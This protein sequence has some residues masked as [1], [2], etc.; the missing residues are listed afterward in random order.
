MSLCYIRTTAY[1]KWQY[2]L[3]YLSAG[4]VMQA[5]DSENAQRHSVSCRAYATVVDPTNLLAMPS[6][7]Y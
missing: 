5:R 2:A 4:Y 7:N 1:S 3:A 6:T